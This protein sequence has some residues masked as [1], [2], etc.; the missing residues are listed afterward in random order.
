[1][2]DVFYIIEILLQI[3]L[4]DMLY[5]GAETYKIAFIVGRTRNL[6]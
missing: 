3:S 4:C 2:H 5:F 6:K 1:M